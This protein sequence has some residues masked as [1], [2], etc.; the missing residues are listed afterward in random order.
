[1]NKDYQD[2]KILIVDDFAS[3]RKLLK[4]TLQELGFNHIKESDD[5]VNALPLLQ[6][7]EFDLLV[8]DWNM[9]Q[10]HGVE[11]V[12]AVRADENLKDLL[13]LMVTAEAKGEYIA[14]AANAGITD[15]IVKPFNKS[16]MNE[17][18]LKIFSRT[19]T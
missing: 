11:L 18:L 5:G 1:M 17:K 13:V 9:P 8:T 6:T 10:M 19:K 7:G 2:I 3:M 12:K 4:T 16:T 15:Y 14:K